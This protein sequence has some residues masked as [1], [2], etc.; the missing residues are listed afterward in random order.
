MAGL[1]DANRDV[2]LTGS[3]LINQ[4]QSLQTTSV[5]YSGAYVRGALV[6]PLSTT[7]DIQTTGA[8]PSTIKAGGALTGNL[9]A[10]LS[11]D[12]RARPATV[13]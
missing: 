4:G 7:T 5:Y 3:S 1:I 8:V 2:N 10:S 11:N 6:W 13:A 12:A 9:S